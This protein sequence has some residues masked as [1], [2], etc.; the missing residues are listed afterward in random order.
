MEMNRMKDEIALLES[1]LSSKLKA[2]GAE[3]IDEA[4]IDEKIYLKKFEEVDEIQGELV[5]KIDRFLLEFPT[6]EVGQLYKDLRLKTI[7]RS[8][9][10]S[11]LSKER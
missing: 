11:N 8:A 10:S 5:R 1:I 9:S 4:N 7:G 2:Y 3:D 6:A